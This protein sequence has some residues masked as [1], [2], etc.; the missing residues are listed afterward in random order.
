MLDLPTPHGDKLRALLQNSK[1][2]GND[3]K[4]VENAI[5]RYSDWLDKLRA[6]EGSYEDIVGKMVSLLDEYKRYLEVELIFDS[7]E[8]FL[9]QQ[10]G[11]LK[12]DSSVIEE[13]LPW[14]V[15]KALS[16][17][18]QGDELTFGPTTCFSSV[19]FESSI[20]MSKPGGGITLR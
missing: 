11:Q 1:L 15:V 8:D 14:L 20:T 5:N 10:K 12:L 9:Y 18:L 2:P 4:R 13:F 3:R 6:V 17:Q 19:R 7:S 16:G